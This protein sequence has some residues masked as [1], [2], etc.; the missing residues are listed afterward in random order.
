MFDTRGRL[1]KVTGSACGPRGRY[2][3]DELGGAGRED[4]MRSTTPMEGNPWPHDMVISVDSDPYH[5]L[6]LLWVR[7]A[8][9]LRPTG[10]QLP[11]GLVD[12]PVR[13]GDSDDRDAWEAAWPEVWEDVVNHAAVLV[14]PSI[15]EELTRTADGSK[16]RAEMIRRLHGP[17]WRERFGDTAFTDDYRAWTEARFHARRD[18]RPR[19][20]AESPERRSLEALIPAWQVGLS[21]VITIPCRGEHA[22]V[23][24]GSALLMTE[25]TRKDPDRYAA[26]LETFARR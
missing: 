11:H 26:A 19:S 25:A 22:R 16:E 3:F 21:K 14:E 12:P 17:T 13:A 18:E 15:F 1:T 10:D 8:W 24:G 7:E 2:W 9:G 4:A 6:E 23:I 5:L 20:L